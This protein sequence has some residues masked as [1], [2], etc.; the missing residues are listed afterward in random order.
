MLLDIIKQAGLGV[1][2][3][4]DKAVVDSPIGSRAIGGIEVVDDHDGM[5]SLMKKL[6]G[7]EQSSHDYEK[8]EGHGHDPCRA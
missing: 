6:S 7:Q 1:F 5:M 8:E 2:G 4:E 3:G